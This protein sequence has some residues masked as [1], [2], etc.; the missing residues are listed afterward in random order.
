MASVWSVK[1]A[2]RRGTSPAP[3]KKCEYQRAKAEGISCY[4]E[5]F[6][7]YLFQII[8]YLDVRKINTWL[9]LLEEFCICR[10]MQPDSI[11]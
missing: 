4:F 9:N 10:S 2:L 11:L 5:L 7:T 3:R 1:N 6:V 8:Q